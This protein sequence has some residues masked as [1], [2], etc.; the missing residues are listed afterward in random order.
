[1]RA[2]T[3]SAWDYPIKMKKCLMMIL[4]AGALSACASHSEI[5]TEKNK[6]VE[7]VYDPKSP[8]YTQRSA[9]KA[10]EMTY[11]VEKLAQASG[12]QLYDHAELMARRPGIQFY[13]VPCANG[14]QVLYKCEMRQCRLVE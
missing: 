6:A 10:G 4:V 9:A 7:N 1:M 11:V 3:E 14:S 13:R 12:C 2:R 5:A 8:L